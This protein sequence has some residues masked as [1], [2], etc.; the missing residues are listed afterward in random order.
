MWS[1]HGWKGAFFPGPRK[2]ATLSEE[3]VSVFGLLYPEGSANPRACCPFC[4]SVGHLEGLLKHSV[5]PEEIGGLVF[6][7]FTRGALVT[8]LQWDLVT[9]HPQGEP[10]STAQ[11]QRAG[12]DQRWGSLLLDPK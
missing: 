12:G 1:L 2:C 8:M 4:Y 6:L 7:E 11:G 10:L 5:G 3:S 9:A